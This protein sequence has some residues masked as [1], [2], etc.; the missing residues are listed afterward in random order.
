M[1][2]RDGRLTPAEFEAI[3]LEHGVLPGYRYYEDAEVACDGPGEEGLE[4]V[5]V[6]GERVPSDG[7]RGDLISIAVSWRIC[8]TLAAGC[9]R[10]PDLDS[11]AANTSATAADAWVD[12]LGDGRGDEAGARRRARTEAPATMERI[13]AGAMRPSSRR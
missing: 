13:P 8:V 7:S 12:R 10:V 9:D 5:F 2:L 6:R 11:T 4:P 3:A 1:S